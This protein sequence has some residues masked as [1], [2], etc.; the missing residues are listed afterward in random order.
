MNTSLRSLR[1]RHGWTTLDVIQRLKIEAHKYI[2]FER[3]WSEQSWQ[4]ICQLCQLF[5]CEPSDIGYLV[6]EQ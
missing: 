3:G 2:N 4:E 6:S 5:E 1:E